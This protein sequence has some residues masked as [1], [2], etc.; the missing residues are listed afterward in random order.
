M[1]A[2][3]AIIGYWTVVSGAMPMDV[4]MHLEKQNLFQINK[5]V[6]RGTPWHL[7][8]IRLEAFLYFYQLIC[9]YYDKQLQLTADQKQI[10]SEIS[11]SAARL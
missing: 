1:A 6:P 7:F 9:R 10:C 2:A 8:E 11:F 5:G 4:I 3:T